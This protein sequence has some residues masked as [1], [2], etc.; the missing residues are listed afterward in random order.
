M[1]NKFTQKLLYK[2]IIFL[3]QVETSLI[4]VLSL[5]LLD[6]KNIPK[7]TRMN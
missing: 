7:E 5:T 3:S 6:K 1:K 2:K 4:N